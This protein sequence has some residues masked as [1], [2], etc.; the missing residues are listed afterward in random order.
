MATLDFGH[1]D[2]IFPIQ[3]NDELQAFQALHPQGQT[4][5]NGN[6]GIG[7]IGKNADFCRNCGS[8]PNQWIAPFFND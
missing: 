1:D 7:L 2:D 8:D 4:I 6:V 3:S 5:M